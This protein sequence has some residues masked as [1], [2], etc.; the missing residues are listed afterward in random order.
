MFYLCACFHYKLPCSRRC[1]K[2]FSRF[3]EAPSGT[4]PV[5]AAIALSCI[6]EQ[7][8]TRN[9]PLIRPDRDRIFICRYVDNRLVVFSDQVAH[10][11]WLQELRQLDFYQHPVELEEVDSGEFFGTILHPEERRLAFIIPDKQFQFKPLILISA[12]SDS[13]KLAAVTAESVSHRA[14]PFLSLKET[15]MCTQSVG[16]M[17]TETIRC[18]KSFASRRSF[19][20]RDR[21][22]TQLIVTIQLEL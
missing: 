12:G 2:F 19:F 5:L 16:N 4:A 10:C 3:A 18:N 14:V 20:E 8:W 9:E 15:G 6:E 7:W 21:L 1:N 11:S 17:S 13:H 22:H